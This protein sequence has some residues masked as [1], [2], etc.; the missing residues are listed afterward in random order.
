MREG[1]LAEAGELLFAESTI[2]ARVQSLGA[3]IARDLGGAPAP[4]VV[5]ILKGSTLFVADLVRALELDVAIDFM[6]I[7]SYADK[8]ESSGR[9]RIVKDLDADIGERDVLLVAGIVDTGLTLN[10]LKRALA[11]REP[12]SL[13]TVSLLDKA[14]RRIVPVGIEYTG[15]AIPDVFVVGYGLDWRGR[16][17]NLRDLFA[18]P[19]VTRLGGHQGRSGE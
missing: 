19:D 17:R 13:R 10:Y 2:Q 8:G 12:R 3:D 9:V 5:G 18:M 11:G 15:F 16:Y 6:S 14:A 1:R 4:V 7:S